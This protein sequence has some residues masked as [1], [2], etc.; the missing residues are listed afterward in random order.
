MK[1][2]ERGNEIRETKLEPRDEE[3]GTETLFERINV[4]RR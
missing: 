3:S 1:L 4:S 2:R